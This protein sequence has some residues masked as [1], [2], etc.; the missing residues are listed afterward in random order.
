MNAAFGPQKYT[1]TGYRMNNGLPIFFYLKTALFPLFKQCCHGYMYDL[2]QKMEEQNV[3]LLAFS[4]AVK[5][6]SQGA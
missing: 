6:G 5:F 2:Y 4:S 1:A 3:N